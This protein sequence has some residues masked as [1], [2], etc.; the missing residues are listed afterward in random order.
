MSTITL[1]SDTIE[2]LLARVASLEA[3]NAV[4]KTIARYMA[5]CDVPSGTLDGETL[6]A[7]FTQDA[8][9]E[10]IG[11]RYTQKFG[12][13]RGHEAILAMLQRYLP[14]VPH[15]AT[16]V[17]FLTSETIAVDGV[18]AKGRWIMLQAS[19]YVDA[20]AELIAARLEIDFVPAQDG[21]NWLIQHFRTE[22][23]FDAPWQ[24]NARKDTT[25]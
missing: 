18:R 20:R 21:R 13:L 15:F 5:L 10:G 11:P 23:L 14:P 25:S 3:E 4:R 7:L 24:V 8:I 1:P 17:H 6:A 22:R 9:W 16:N 2:A 19:G 12:H